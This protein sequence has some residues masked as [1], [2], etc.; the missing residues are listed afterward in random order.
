MAKS[1]GAPPRAPTRVRVRLGVEDRRAQLIAVGLSQFATR[2]YEDI[3]MD[4]LARA[5]EISKGLLY[6]YFPSKHDYYVAVLDHAAVRLVTETTPV[7]LDLPPLER[8]RN[9]L[10]TYFDF[11]DRHGPAFTALMRGGIGSDPEV[12]A[13]LER[14]RAAFVDRILQDLPPELDTLPLRTALRGWIGFVEAVATEWI[15]KR[16]VSKDELIVMI[17]QV[18]LAAVQGTTGHA[19]R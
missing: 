11:V 16:A 15:L 13:I 2:S 19:L 14:T 12:S 18:L 9:G 8:L 7:A 5:A 1:D 6:H 3:S 10:V 17:S 4:D